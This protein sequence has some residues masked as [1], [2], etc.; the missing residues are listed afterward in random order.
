MAKGEHMEMLLVGVEKVLLLIGI[1]G[2]L[3]S[4][5]EYG[6][7]SQDWKGVITVFYK[8]VDMTVHEF[9]FYK[10]GISLLLFAA[11]LRVGILT[12]YP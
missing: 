6:K 11:V 4:L 1:G 7:R 9:K 12:F 5:Y 2:V 3:F 8:R 10:L